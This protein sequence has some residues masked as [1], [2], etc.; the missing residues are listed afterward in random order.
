MGVSSGG[1]TITLTAF[2]F[3]SPPRPRDP[4]L[5]SLCSFFPLLQLVNGYFPEDYQEN[6]SVGLR[7]SL[8]TPL[9]LSLSPFLAFP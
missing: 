4:Y 3:P 1:G 6:P 9:T 2:F 8:V 5:F 7:V